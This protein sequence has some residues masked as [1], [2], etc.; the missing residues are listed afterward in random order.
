MFTMPLHQPAS[1]YCGLGR[2]G[3]SRKAAWQG[4]V[5]SNV[6][7]TDG[8]FGRLPVLGANASLFGLSDSVAIALGNPEADP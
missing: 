8:A 1:Q 6:A 3:T 2:N 7:G 5:V 4:R